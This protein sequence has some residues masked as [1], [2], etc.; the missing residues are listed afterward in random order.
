M[1]N[2]IK[3]C[4]NKVSKFYDSGRGLRGTPLKNYTSGDGKNSGMESMIVS[5]LWQIIDDIGIARSRV[6][7]TNDYFNPEDKELQDP[8]RMDM[9]IKIDDKYPLI[10]E[11]RA[12]IDKPF[13]TLKRAVTRNMMM[14]PYVRERL[15]ED[16]EF[17]YVALAIDI[18]Q[19][20][21]TTL[22]ATQGYGDRINMFKFSPKRRSS[23]WNYFDNGV[24]ESGVIDFVSFVHKKLSR[25]KEEK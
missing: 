25:Y 19:R 10:I 9:H 17:I 1:N 4:V 3:E 18:K 23:K 11:S 22:D 6:S 13:Y 12:W 24:E 5:L 20:L 21:I 14:L 7:I 2:V 15:T 16:V 8:Q